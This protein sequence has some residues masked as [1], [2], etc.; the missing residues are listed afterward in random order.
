LEYAGCSNGFFFWLIT[1]NLIRG[2]WTLLV[3]GTFALLK[4]IA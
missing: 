2:R 3:E 1:M 4:G